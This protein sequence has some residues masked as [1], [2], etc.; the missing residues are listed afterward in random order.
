VGDTL[1]S[2]G[3][4]QWYGETGLALN[5]QYFSMKTRRYMHDHGITEDCVHRVA[6]KAGHRFT[7]Y[8]SSFFSSSS[9]PSPGRSGRSRSPSS[10]T[11]G[12]TRISSK[13]RPDL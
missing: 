11:K 8:L 10:Q 4:G 7:A 1:E 3:L 9:K 5:P 2:I 13:K 12:S 6:A